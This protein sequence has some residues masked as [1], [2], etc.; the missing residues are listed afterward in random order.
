MTGYMPLGCPAKIWGKR[1]GRFQRGMSVAENCRKQ[2]IGTQ[3]CR[4]CEEAL[5]REEIDKIAL[6]V[7]QRNETGNA[8]WERQRFSAREDVA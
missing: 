4:H 8:F 2:G 1:S 6:F 3:L 5:G 7:F